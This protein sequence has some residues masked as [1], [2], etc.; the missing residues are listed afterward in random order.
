ML[1]MPAVPRSR[2]RWV[3]ALLVGVLVGG[4]LTLV[5]PPAVQPAAAADL[6]AFDPGLIIT[7]DI[8]FNGRGMSASQIQSFIRGKDPTC[9]SFTDGGTHYTCLA[10]YAM[11]TTTQKADVNCGGYTGHTSETAATIIARVAVACGINPEVLLVV[12][13]KEQGLITG[14]AR[15]S[16]IYRKAMGYGCPDSSVCDT[17]YYGFFNQVYR[18]AWQFEQYRHF[19]QNHTIQAGRTIAIQYNPKSSCGT[20][21]VY[22]RNQATAGLY[23][24][25]PYVPNSAA[26]K[27]GY[28]LGDSCSS[29]G[30]RNFFNYFTDYFGNPANRLKNPG[31][32][33]GRGTPY[34]TAGTTGGVSFS[35]YNSGTYA[36]SG[37]RYMRISTTKPGARVKQTVL[38]KSTVN[39]IYSGGIWLRASTTGAVVN[40]SVNLWAD[41]G[42]STEK[43]SQPFAV[44]S[45]WVFVSTDLTVLKP[46]H[47]DLRLFV[48]V[49][50]PKQYLRMDDGTLYYSGTYI[51]PQVPMVNNGLVNPGFES[52]PGTTGWV[53]G[54][55][56]TPAYD[57]NRSTTYAHTGSGY[58]R[59]NTATAGARIKQTVVHT[60]AAG[61][62]YDGNLWLR[63]SADTSITGQL[64]VYAAGGSAAIESVSVPFSV[65][66]TWTDVKATLPLSVA[67]HTEL[68]FVLQVD[69]TGQYLRADDAVLRLTPAP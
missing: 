69:T 13:Q 4:I 3:A 56:S 26:L 1:K 27:A 36:H 68:R 12:M 8:F 62:S 55:D 18:S 29:Y 9:K 59:F 53:P 54:T 31:I 52:T 57:V 67:G 19:P 24:Y 66:P 25:T 51:P 16:L 10:D 48:E 50:S 6:T 20:K 28:G 32:E 42:G 39:G 46:G 65:G 63:S 21:N 64:L 22:I 58:L 43:V 30:N 45:S 61:E 44:T 38:Y 60:T 5:A 40:G 41:G 35:A 14:G 37:S 23:I 47:T 11:K 15:N 33:I 17:K 49:D 2:T 7:D 34:W